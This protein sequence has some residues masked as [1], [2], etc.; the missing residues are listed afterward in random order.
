[1]SGNL[2]K[3]SQKFK[4]FFTRNDFSQV[5]PIKQKRKDILNWLSLVI[6]FLLQFS[7]ITP[8]YLFWSSISSVSAVKYIFSKVG[9]LFLY[10]LVFGSNF[11]VIYIKEEIGWFF[12]KKFCLKKCMLIIVPCLFLTQ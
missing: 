5:E 7:A 9:K 8:Y 11:P 6:L 2:P 3:P 12:L 10:I 4:D 1:M